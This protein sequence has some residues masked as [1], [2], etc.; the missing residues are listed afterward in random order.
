MNEQIALYD[1][2]NCGHGRVA[3]STGETADELKDY[4][5]RIIQPENGYRF[6][7]DPLLLCNFVSTP[8]AGILDLGTGCGIIPLVMA[9]K[10]PDSS[11]VGVEL[12][13]EMAATARRNVDLNQ[14][15][16]RISILEADILE[17]SKHYGADSFD[18]VIANPPYRRIGTG[19]VS[20]KKGRDV[21][22]HESTANLADFLSIARRMVKPE[23]SIVFI[24]QTERLP[25]FMEV[26]GR[27]KLSCQRLQ[28][29]HGRID[30][31]ARMFMVELFK[32]RR[33]AL[34]VL[35]VLLVR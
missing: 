16:K 15:G 23:G 25:E 21:A 18:L 14:L 26:A 7:L 35:P 33:G 28:M 6:S 20:P 29:V 8:A 30:A 32:G 27:L 10:F 13:S 31:Q 3:S 9:R 11:I 2:I 17:L 5:L 22:R 4:D 12:Q 19:K 1:R 24:Y 34:Q